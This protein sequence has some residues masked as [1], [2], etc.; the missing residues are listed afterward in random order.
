MPK[1]T[2]IFDEVLLK[3]LKKAGKNAEIRRALSRMFDRLELLGPSLGN[4]I[5][6]Q[7]HLY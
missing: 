4:L 1:F 2:L 6:T 5:D 3:Q 7:L